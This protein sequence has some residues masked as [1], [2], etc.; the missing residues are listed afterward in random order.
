MLDEDP[1]D[2]YVIVILIAVGS[3]DVFVIE[4]GS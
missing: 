4:S 1:A 3:T 2:P